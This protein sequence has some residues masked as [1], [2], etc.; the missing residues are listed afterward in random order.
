MCKK[1]KYILCVEG[2]CY[3]VNVLK[4]FKMIVLY[5]RFLFN[6]YIFYGKWIEI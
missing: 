4:Y 1:I 3:F 2:I 5:L 6:E